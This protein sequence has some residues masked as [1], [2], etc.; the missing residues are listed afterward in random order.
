MWLDKSPFEAS[1]HVCTRVYTYACELK[2]VK[3]LP[4]EPLLN[5]N[6]LCGIYMLFPFP[7]TL[8]PLGAPANVKLYQDT[9]RSEAEEGHGDR[10]CMTM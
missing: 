2:V 5:F 4:Y 1:V 8:I 6:L 9:I 7:F 10:P 3:G